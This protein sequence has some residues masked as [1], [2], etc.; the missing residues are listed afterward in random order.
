M[1]KYLLFL[2][3]CI[4]SNF[5]FCQNFPYLLNTTSDS[6]VELS[7][8]VSLNS[9]I[10]TEQCSYPV[11][12]NFDFDIMGQTYTSCNVL[13]GAILFGED[14][15]PRINIIY[16]PFGGLFLKDRGVTESESP[17]G[18]LIEGNEGERVVKI[19][20]KN[21][22][23]LEWYEFDPNNDYDNFQIWLFEEDNHIEIHFGPNSS[24]Y[25]ITFSDFISCLFLC[26]DPMGIPMFGSADNPTYDYADFS[27]PIYFFLNS[28]PSDGIVYNF[29]PNLNYTSSQLNERSGKL[30]IYPNPVD[31][32]LH[33][34]LS[35][36]GVDALVLIYDNMGRLVK[37]VQIQDNQNLINISE[38]S[39]GSYTMIIHSN[40]KT[41]LH[42]KFIKI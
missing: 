13:A 37:S 20:W 1:K 22:G 7:N 16:T 27:E 32:I 3:I 10:W 9:G 30:N 17:I 5:A 24:N 18:Y 42:T 14:G 6:Y 36:C 2:S 38:L 31:N 29:Y 11:S 34:Q 8:P 15:A 33:L 21:A 40:D 4:I 26:N 35:E 39:S 12:F 25:G 23:F 41:D 19:Q 28:L